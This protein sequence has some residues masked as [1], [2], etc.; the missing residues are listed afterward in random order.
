MSAPK[1]V[2]VRSVGD[3][4]IV[5][6]V[7]RKLLEDITIQEVGFEM[8]RLVEGEGCKVLLL[9]FSNVTFMSAA[10]LGKLITLD[11]KIKEHNGRLAMSG[12]CKK[13]Y[14][15]MV[16]TRLDR[17]FRIFDDEAAALEYLNG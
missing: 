2:T 11:K 4:T 14:E 15:T 13:D 5:E 8:F 16:V 17:L 1:R 12:L 6:F 9:N 3:T 10:F 7:G